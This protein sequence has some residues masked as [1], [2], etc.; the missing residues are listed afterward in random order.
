MECCLKMTTSA[1]HV[2]PAAAAR[3]AHAHAPRLALFAPL[4]SSATAT[5]EALKLRRD[6]GGGGVVSAQLLAFVNSLLHLNDT[7]KHYNHD[8]NN[9]NNNN[10][11]K[12]GLLFSGVEASLADLGRDGTE[13]RESAELI[14]K[15]GLELLVNI[16]VNDN[17]NV[18]DN[19]DAT[20]ICSA[21]VSSSSSSRRALEFVKSFESQLR[22]VSNLGGVVS[23]VN[24]RGSDSDCNYSAAQQSV[25]WWDEDK[26]LEYLLEVLPLSAQF[27][28]DH[29]YIG[30]NGNETDVMGGSPH[31]LIGISHE[32]IGRS[33]MGN[34]IGNGN[35]NGMLHHP[36]I[37][38]NLLE[39]VPP[40]RLTMDLSSW[41]ED[42]G[43]PWGSSVNNNNNNGDDDDDDDDEAEAL[44]VE[45]VPH[46]DLIRTK[47]SLLS[48]CD[49]NNNNNDNNNP[50]DNDRYRRTH[51]SLW[52]D[53]WTRKA[54]RGVEQLFMT[55]G[56]DGDA[57]TTVNDTIVAGNNDSDDNENESFTLRRVKR[58]GDSANCIHQFYDSWSSSRM[59]VETKL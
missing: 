10:N 45:I 22:A 2:V 18:D 55:L 41:H 33:D 25:L 13:Q 34:G 58:L 40:L 43:F 30:R 31:H 16:D 19:V 21:V 46:I 44:S 38:R 26:T 48:I 51:Q 4:R 5:T 7:Y 47:T 8:N 23:H 57:T 3:I 32:N 49:N 1:L 20:T 15:S 52:E 11:N 56:D 35:G 29:P 17:V 28:E 12:I 9:S 50:A 27:L 37:A 24:C 54:N 53:V 36:A 14:Q 59:L 6:S 39:V 42:C